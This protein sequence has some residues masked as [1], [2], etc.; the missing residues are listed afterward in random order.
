MKKINF[1]LLGLLL[2]LQVGF[3]RSQDDSEVVKINTSVIQVDATVTDKNGR[4]ITDLKPEDFEIFENGTKRQITGF[5]FI[6]SSGKTGNV[7]GGLL[8]TGTNSN[9]AAP[10]LPAAGQIRRILAVV[11]DDLLLSKTGVEYAKREITK[12]VGQQVEPGDLVAIIKTSGSVGVLQKFTSDKAQLLKSIES[13]SFHPLTSIGTS[14]FA[15]IGISFSNQIISNITTGGAVSGSSSVVSN[16]SD[17]EASSNTFRNQ[18]NALGGLQVLRN[19]I[20]A[21][22]YLKG[23]KTLLFVSEGA[24]LGFSL[25]NKDAVNSVNDNEITLATENSLKI[26]DRNF[27]INS[28]LQVITESANRNSVSIFPIDPSGAAATNLSAD[29]STRG[30]M[31]DS[32]SRAQID[33]VSVGRSD[34]IRTAQETLKYLAR[35]TGGK[36]FINKNDYGK[37]IKDVFDALKGY[38]LLAYEP[39][40]G[41]FNVKDSRFNKL[42]IKVKRPNLNVSYRSGFFNVSTGSKQKPTAAGDEILQKL[43]VPYNFSD[44]G[45][46]VTSIYAG[47]EKNNATIRSFIN[48]LPNNLTVSDNTTEKKSAK[49]DLVVAIFNEDGVT[50]GSSARNYE[51]SFDAKSYDNFL[52]SGV[53]SNLTFNIQKAGTYRIKVLVKDSKSNKIGTNSQTVFVPDTEKQLI[54]LS[55]FLLQNYTAAQWQDLQKNP[56]S[57][58]PQK[59]QIDTAF[60]HFKKGTVLA[61]TYALNLSPTLAKNGNSKLTLTT[62]LLKDNQVVFTFAPEEIPIAGQTAQRVNRRSAFNLGTEMPRGK[63]T[64]QTVADTDKSHNTE[65]QSIDFEVVE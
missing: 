34:N 16:R 27:E 50:V 56:A 15:P 65:M 17:I 44:I 31:F 53:V 61:F 52:K 18:L 26:V 58:N 20:D 35:E 5:S 9:L 10:P 24:N 49:F 38:Y 45:V 63:Y 3:V 37:E 12:F 39:D 4:V 21:M 32:M 29:D 64:L 51:V 59:M 54:G 36:A 25:E 13:I 8:L 19:T 6:D 48:I 33:A 42:E 43:F 11:I 2:V 28:F 22:G 62:K 57:A 60:R 47:T 46:E 1:T 14:R 40:E 7:S 55:G 41:T 23:K 30:G